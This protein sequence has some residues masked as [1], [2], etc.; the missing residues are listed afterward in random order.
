[1]RQPRGEGDMLSDGADLASV[2]GFAALGTGGALK[3]L[4]Q[5]LGLRLLKLAAEALICRGSSVAV[6]AAALPAWT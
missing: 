5:H 3:V 1:M 2:D 4:V 6:E